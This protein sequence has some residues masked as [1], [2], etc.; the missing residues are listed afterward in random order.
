MTEIKIFCLKSAIFQKT[1]HNFDNV[2]EIYKIALLWANL[3][4]TS[5][6]IYFLE[7]ELFL[8]FDFTFSSFDAFVSQ[9]EKVERNWL[10]KLLLLHLHFNFWGNT[11]FAFPE[12]CFLLQWIYVIPERKH[13]KVW[14]I[15]MS[16]G[17]IIPRCHS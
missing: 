16:K 8:D 10:Q 6:S 2:T 3:L 12:R 17:F 9:K 11:T 15:Y 4:I 5:K 14:M 1:T 13:L 7:S